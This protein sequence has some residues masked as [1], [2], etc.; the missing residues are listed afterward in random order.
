MLTPHYPALHSQVNV[1][2]TLDRRCCLADFG[3]AG[4]VAQAESRSSAEH[5]RTTKGSTRWMAPEMLTYECPPSKAS[6]ATDIY[7]FGCTVLEVM[8]SPSEVLI[9]FYLFMI[10]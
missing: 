9:T 8:N 2:V 1:L 10:S 3:L 6:K 7:A 5:S 4:I